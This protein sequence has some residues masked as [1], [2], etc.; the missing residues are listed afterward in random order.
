MLHYSFAELHL[1]KYK[2]HIKNRDDFKIYPSL[3]QTADLYFGRMH[4]SQESISEGDQTSKFDLGLTESSA[5]CSSSN[6]G[7]RSMVDVTGL[8]LSRPGTPMGSGNGT[9][10]STM[11]LMSSIGIMQHKNK[12]EVVISHKTKVSQVRIKIV[13]FIIILHWKYDFTHVFY[14][15]SG[16]ATSS[17]CL[18]LGMGYY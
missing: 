14:F 5:T 9:P 6:T 11:T 13:F 3:L 12:N 15:P 1:V 7:S 10:T 2:K 17:D 4:P 16:Q 8:T 18:R